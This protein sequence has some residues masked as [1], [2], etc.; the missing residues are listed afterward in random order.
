LKKE[1]FDMNFQITMKFDEDVL[2]AVRKTPEEFASEIRLLAA[3]KWYESG[4]ISQEKAAQI[5]GMSRSDFLAAISGIR[6]SPF[7]YT[8]EE[9]M[10]EVGNVR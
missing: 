10:E 3:A 4:V 8:A 7:Q 5:A 1:I 2:P 9:V 6:I